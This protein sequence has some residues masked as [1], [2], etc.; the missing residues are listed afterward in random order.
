MVM[1]F[2]ESFTFLKI[3]VLTELNSIKVY[4]IEVYRALKGKKERG[5]WTSSIKT[6]RVAE[7]KGKGVAF[8]GAMFNSVIPMQ[9]VILNTHFWTFCYFLVK[10]CLKVHYS[11]IW[12]CCILNLLRLGSIR[13]G[14]ASGSKMSGLC[15][16]HQ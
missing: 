11:T 4:F 8:Q 16:N 14:E 7:K 2:R 5:N 6:T 10:K 9:F 13:N 3:Y 1:K 12:I 15:Q